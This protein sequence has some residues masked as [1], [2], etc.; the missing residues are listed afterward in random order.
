MTIEVQLD[1]IEGET[2]KTQEAAKA[3]SLPPRKR[4]MPPAPPPRPRVKPIPRED[5]E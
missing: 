5:P 2:A 1:W 4:S 3:A